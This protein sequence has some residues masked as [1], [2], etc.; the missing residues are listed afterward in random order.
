MRMMGRGLA[1]A[2]AAAVA[3]NMAV[4]VALAAATYAPAAMAATVAMGTAAGGAAGQEPERWRAVE[5]PRP[6][7]LEDAAVLAR[8]AAMAGDGERIYIA[9]AIDCAVKVFSRDGRF[10][11]AIGRKG[12]GPGELAMPSGVAVAAGGAVAVADKLNFRVQWFGADGAPRGGFKVPAAPDRVLVLGEDRLLVTFNATGRGPDERLLRAYD[13]R[14]REL[15][16]GL[17]P[18]RSA[19]PVLD[20]FRNMI[21]VCPGEDGDVFVVRR[22][23]ERTIRRFSA[24]GRELDPIA[25]DERHAF[26]RLELP[27]PRGVIRLDGFCWAADRDGGLLYLAAPDA[28]DGGRDLGPGR[29]VSVLD[30]RGRLRAV[31]ELACPVHRFIV[32]GCRLFAID[33]E[34]ELR[35]FEVAR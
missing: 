15:W 9:D 23:G 24:A 7:S 29:T 10:L 27:G 4:A 28:L 30:E 20:A 34:G 11:R 12:A 1:A 8:P 13:P 33:S 18:V 3:A 17:E 22:S 35:I 19:D 6:A 2:A 21:A 31:I 14:G 26:R 16:T 32:R 25:A 5:V